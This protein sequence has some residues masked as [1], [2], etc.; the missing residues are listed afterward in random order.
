MSVSNTV[1]RDTFHFLPHFLFSF[2]F[3]P[4]SHLFPSGAFCRLV[5]KRCFPSQVRGSDPIS[6]FECIVTLSLVVSN[7]FFVVLYLF[8]SLVL[9]ALLVL[10]IRS[11]LGWCRLSLVSVTLFDS[12]AM[13]YL[14]VYMLLTCC[15]PRLVLGQCRLCC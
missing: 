10:V 6:V 1:C 13:L 9:S 15:L 14:C 8:V 7:S 12:L 4:S 11:R 5:R 3:Q 2:F